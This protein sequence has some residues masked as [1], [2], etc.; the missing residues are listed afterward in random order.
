MSDLPVSQALEVVDPAAPALERTSIADLVHKLHAGQLA[1]EQLP[2]ELRRQCVAHLTLEGFTTGEITQ[3]MG[4]TERT[5][6]RD[7][8]AV[9]RDEA[10]PPN[11]A[12]GDELLGEFHRLTLSSIQRLIRLAR[13]TSTPH[14]ARLWAEEAAVR[15]YQRLIDTARRMNYIE[16]GSRRLRHLRDGTSPDDAKTLTQHLTQLQRAILTGST[17]RAQIKP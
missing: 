6:R 1:A 8:Q 5:V 14:Y 11:P 12:L 4:V 2:Q 10:Q 15:I 9:R 3:L 16:D 13:D 17:P 7:R